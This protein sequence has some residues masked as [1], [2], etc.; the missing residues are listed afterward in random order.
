MTLPHG[1]AGIAAAHAGSEPQV[2]NFVPKFADPISIHDRIM[3]IHGNP[4]QS[5]A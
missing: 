4:W 2:E 3:A 5:M 1:I